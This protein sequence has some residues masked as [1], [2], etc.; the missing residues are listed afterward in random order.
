MTALALLFALGF[1][2]TFAAAA[3]AAGDAADVDGEG[4][5]EEDADD[6]IALQTELFEEKDSDGDGELDAH[7]FR[8]ML[9]EDIHPDERMGEPEVAAVFRQADLDDNKKVSLQEWMANFF[10]GSPQIAQ[11]RDGDEVGA[12]ADEGAALPDAE[13]ARLHARE[14]FDKLD[15]DGSGHLSEAEILGMLRATA[16]HSPYAARVD[17]D[18]GP[19]SNA[20]ENGEHAAKGGKTG[21][22]QA[23][24]GQVDG[25]AWGNE[26]E[27]DM[28]RLAA[29]MVRD[30]DIDRDSLVR[31]AACS[32]PPLASA[33]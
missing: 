18:G 2:G 26:D 3:A 11:Y 23:A 7:E 22:E 6:I 10:H 8:A 14:Q 28:Q 24:D 20:S 29:Q 31:Y 21:P 33:R 12:E 15:G 27:K 32:L 25:M 9:L 13:E 16:A 4:Q 19:Q 1:V 17:G 5:A 30:L